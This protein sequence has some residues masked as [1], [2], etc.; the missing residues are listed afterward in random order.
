MRKPNI[1]EKASPQNYAETARESQV[2][3]RCV[4]THL[5]VVLSV[6]VNCVAEDAGADMFA[7]IEFPDGPGRRP[8]DRGI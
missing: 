4:L 5:V 3:K 1:P 7:G 8:G 6:F 2:L